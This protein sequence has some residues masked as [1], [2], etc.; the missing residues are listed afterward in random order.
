MAKAAALP[1]DQRTKVQERLQ[2]AREFLCSQDPLDFF[3]AWK[4]PSERYQKKFNSFEDDCDDASE[5]EHLR[6]RFRL[7]S[8]L[9]LVNAGI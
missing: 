3:L 9:S 1:E 7:V 2:V 8:W 5:S 6:I 4:T